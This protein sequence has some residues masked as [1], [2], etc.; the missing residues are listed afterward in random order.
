MK[1]KKQTELVAGML[2]KPQIN[3]LIKTLKKIT[4]TG[5]IPLEE[6]EVMML[7]VIVDDLK[8]WEVK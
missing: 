2:S 6:K 5:F 3:L 7:K 1:D 4:K 8:E